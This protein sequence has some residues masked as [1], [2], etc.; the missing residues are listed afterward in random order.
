MGRRVFDEYSG[1]VILKCGWFRTTIHVE[2]GKNYHDIFIPLWEVGVECDYTNVLPLHF[3]F[4]NDVD[5]EIANKTQLLNH[6]LPEPVSCKNTKI[7]ISA[8]DLK[9]II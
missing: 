1:K 6:K 9:F 5:P 4:I 3:T 7:R 2:R 8:G